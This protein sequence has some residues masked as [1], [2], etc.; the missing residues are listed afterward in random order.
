MAPLQNIP[1]VRPGDHVRIELKGVPAWNLP[2][3]ILEADV[4]RENVD[5][6]QAEIVD[7]VTYGKAK[8][9]IN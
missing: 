5:P 8:V 4:T 2:P 7:A 3:Q 9:T 1:T 6:V